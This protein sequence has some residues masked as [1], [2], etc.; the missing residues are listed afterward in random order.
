M[1]TIAIILAGLAYA[2]W[3]LIKEREGTKMNVVK[4][5]HS[6]CGCKGTPSYD[7]FDQVHLFPDCV[8]AAWEEYQSR[9]MPI[10]LDAMTKYCRGRS[11]TV[12][13]VGAGMGHFARYARARGCR[14]ET[15]EPCPITA[16]RLQEEGFVV[17]CRTP[18]VKYDMVHANGVIEHVDRPV[19]FADELFDCTKP[20]GTCWVMTCN[21]LGLL[22]LCT[23]FRML[24]FKLFSVSHYICKWHVQYWTR[25]H[26]EGILKDAGFEICTSWTD[27]WQQPPKRWSLRR[28]VHCLIFLHQVNIVARRP[29]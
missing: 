5:M 1:I 27:P 24:T 22:V 17:H 4:W 26:V 29:I 2:A 12:L 14:V 9:Q 19:A 8:V 18:F 21:E 16:K 20:G 3:T 28:I 7:S 15:V 23:I 10:R 6:V 13:D 11:L 25:G